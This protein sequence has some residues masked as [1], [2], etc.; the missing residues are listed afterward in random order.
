MP[1]IQERKSEQEVTLI[2][3][4]PYILFFSQKPRPSTKSVSLRHKASEGKKMTSNYRAFPAEFQPFIFCAAISRP[5]S[6][7]KPLPRKDLRKPKT[8]FFPFPLFKTMYNKHFPI[9]IN[10]YDQSTYVS[11]HFLRNYF[12]PR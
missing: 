7:H 5:L 12:T 10:P 8:E 3:L 11:T 6:R 4:P 9:D 2:S 1:T